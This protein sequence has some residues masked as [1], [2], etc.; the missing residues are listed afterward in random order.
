MTLTEGF[1][2]TPNTVSEAIGGFDPSNPNQPIGFPAWLI[3]PRGRLTPNEKAVILAI[4]FLIAYRLYHTHQNIADSAGISLSTT[5]RVL[6]ELKKRGLVS[7]TKSQGYENE[8]SL[9]LCYEQE[10][11]R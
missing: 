1:G 7:W 4:S 11:Q 10:E 8:Y 6:A 3:T 9:H 2:H 5:K